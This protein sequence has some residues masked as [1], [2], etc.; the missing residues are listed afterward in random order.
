[1]QGFAKCEKEAA[2]FTRAS[3]GEACTF[4]NLNKKVPKMGKVLTFPKWEYILSA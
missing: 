4:K 3:P 2:I 1:L